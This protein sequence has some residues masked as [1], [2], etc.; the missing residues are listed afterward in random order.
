MKRV[1]ERKEKRKISVLGGISTSAS[2]ENEELEG[3]TRRSRSIFFQCRNDTRVTQT[4]CYIEAEVLQ[5]HGYY[6][7][8]CRER[9]K[10]KIGMG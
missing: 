3:M 2:R 5:S 4:Q 8:N 6:L 9:E 7:L 10:N 1:I